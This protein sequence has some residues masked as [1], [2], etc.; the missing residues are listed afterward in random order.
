MKI[1]TVTV[2]ADRHLRVENAPRGE[3]PPPGFVRHLQSEPRLFTIV[4]TICYPRSGHMPS[5]LFFFLLASGV[6]GLADEGL[7]VWR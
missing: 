1:A 4:Q 2:R 6:L 7:R 5:E 3:Y